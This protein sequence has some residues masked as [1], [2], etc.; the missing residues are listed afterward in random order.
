MRN[1]GSMEME[2]HIVLGLL[3]LVSLL[4]G[5]G[6]FLIWLTLLLG[7]SL[8]SIT[9]DFANLAYKVMSSCPVILGSMN[10]PKLIPGFSSRTFSRCSFAK[11]M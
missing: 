9:E 4:V 1:L 11:N 6:L 8:P 3:I 5:S 2:A 10:L 7:Q